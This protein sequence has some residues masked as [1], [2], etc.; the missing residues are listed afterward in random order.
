MSSSSSTAGNTPATADQTDNLHATA[1]TAASSPPA[2]QAITAP[3]APVSSPPPSA[4]TTSPPSLLEAATSGGTGRL[5]GT[6]TGVHLFKPAAATG[7]KA[8]AGSK[9]PPT[10]TVKPLISRPVLQAATPNAASLIA[11]A[12]STGISQSSILAHKGEG[13][14]GTETDPFK[15]PREKGRRAVFCD[16]ITLPSPTS[17]NTPPIIHQ[18]PHG[19]SS[20]VTSAAAAGGPAVGRLITPTWSTQPLPTAATAQVCRINSS[21]TSPEKEKA[22]PAVVV[23]RADEKL[24]ALS[25]VPATGKEPSSSSSSSFSKLISN[26]KRTPSLS[27]RHAQQ[28]Q[29]VT[30][31]DKKDD[32]CKPSTLPRKPKT[33]G[34]GGGRPER[35]SLRNLEI[36]GPVLQTSVDHA[37]LHLV[38][39]VCR[40]P[41]LS[42]SD[43]PPTTSPSNAVAV[44]GGGGAHEETGGG[45]TSRQAGGSPSLKR[46]APKPPGSSSKTA[47]GSLEPKAAAVA[48]ERK[49]SL[50]ND[51]LT[52]KA[53][54][55][56]KFSLPWRSV[57]PASRAVPEP[58]FSEEK[59]AASVVPPPVPKSSSDDIL[60]QQK[61][62]QLPGHGSLQ[63]S[64][65]MRGHRRPASIATSKP[66]RPNAP[67]PKP[68][69]TR[70][71]SHET[72]P[73]DIYIYDDAS[74]VIS[75][76]GRRS[77]SSAAP[78]A[79]IEE[80]ASPPPPSSSS[81]HDEPIYDTIGDGSSKRSSSSLGPDDD[82]LTPPGSPLTKKSP[83]TL[84][85]GSS[86]A[87]ED[88]LMREILR[89]VVTS[90]RGPDGQESIYSSLM[91]RKKKDRKL[92]QR[93][94]SKP[95]SPEA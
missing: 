12:P 88:G 65:S 61:K 53:A 69:P 34:G 76:G 51:D 87:E 55:S 67:P 17:P 13:R 70:A 37:R 43:S 59:P 27:D 15:P 75:R 19:A 84:S 45:A 74:A 42:G 5:G 21:N 4:T 35:Q 68:P 93:N 44:G 25:E 28:Q 26:V 16:P 31:G 60:E 10:A 83:D 23:V 50:P 80:S 20:D 82:F 38:P 89:E 54:S 81:C 91:R 71:G 8:A 6:T 79:H 72:S 40:S 22:A 63:A 58:Q 77:G 52:V 47:M 49:T 18:P 3:S 92:K 62:Q 46:P 48:T 95:Q 2:V 7:G 32:N 24:A 86:G 85:T 57:K 41:E 30:A 64:N 11:R 29:L 39:V 78:L 1:K 73:D 66:V 14:G 33:A 36:S 94:S 9:L 90:S 56:S